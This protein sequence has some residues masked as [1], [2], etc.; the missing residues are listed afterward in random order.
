MTVRELIALLEEYDMD[1]PVHLAFWDNGD[2]EATG[3][4]IEKEFIS[5]EHRA[6]PVYPNRHDFKRVVIT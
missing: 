4:E 2:P 6:E 3:F 1:L 5:V